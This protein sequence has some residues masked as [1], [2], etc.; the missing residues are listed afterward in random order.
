MAE[1]RM[2]EVCGE[3]PTTP[4][5]WDAMVKVSPDLAEGGYRC[6]A[7]MEAFSDLLDKHHHVASTLPKGPALRK[8]ILERKNYNWAVKI[9]EAATDLYARGK[10]REAIE[11]LAKAIP[12]FREQGKARSLA[13]CLGNC[14][15]ILTDLGRFAEALTYHQEEEDICRQNDWKTDLGVCLFNQARALLRL[16]RI[17]RP[18]RRT[19]KPL[20]C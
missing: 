11:N 6:D 2:C 18:G 16:H 7:C 14:G 20:P 3:K 19:R 13:A 1:T 12:V 10:A 4:G 15:T 5:L 9:G 17:P 8:A